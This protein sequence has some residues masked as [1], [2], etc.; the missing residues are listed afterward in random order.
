MA[1]KT[2]INEVYHLIISMDSIVFLV[3]GD[4]KTILKRTLMILNMEDDLKTLCESIS[5]SDVVS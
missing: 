3:E 5:L 2:N 1:D 4:R